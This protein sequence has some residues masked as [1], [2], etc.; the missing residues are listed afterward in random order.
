MQN[1]FRDAVR[2]AARHLKF[3]SDVGDLEVAWESHGGLLLCRSREKIWSFEIGCHHRRLRPQGRRC[4]LYTVKS[5]RSQTVRSRYLRKAALHELQRLLHSRGP[6]SEEEYAPINSPKPRATLRRRKLERL[7]SNTAPV[8]PAQLISGRVKV[9]WDWKA[10]SRCAERWTFS[11]P[12][13]DIEVLEEMD[14][15][16]LEVQHFV[17][18]NWT[19]GDVECPAAKC[20]ESSCPGGTE[21]V[22]SSWKLAPIIVAHTRIA[23]SSLDEDTTQDRQNDLWTQAMLICQLLDPEVL[24]ASFE[25]S[26]PI[27]KSIS[28]VSDKS[29]LE[30]E[31][32]LQDCFVALVQ[33]LPSILMSR[34]Y[35]QYPHRNELVAYLLK[36]TETLARA[37]SQAS[38]PIRPHSEEVPNELQT[39]W[40]TVERAAFHNPTI[41]AATHRSMK[42]R[43]Q[44]D[45]S[46]T[47]AQ[48]A[49]IIR[50]NLLRRQH[51]DPN[52]P[53][54]SVSWFC[55]KH[56]VHRTQVD[57]AMSRMRKDGYEFGR[58]EGMKTYKLSTTDE[59]ELL[60]RLGLTPTRAVVRRRKPSF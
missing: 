42:H 19:E 59:S 48:L 16:L 44:I 38:T 49:E 37:S 18:K 39:P 52:G 7:I 32:L 40:E 20:I 4:K 45:G 58:V 28:R 31:E 1:L 11:P 43:K 9:W 30:L 5:S 34:H 22:Q 8:Y 15:F 26:G 51:R 17:I 3:S 54:R 57:R 56:N 24:G 13:E 33:R 2:L 23:N 53:D 60:R 36:T 10:P 29:S 35:S 41:C 50:L 46:E 47:S 25:T 6:V 21:I 14:R 12:I 55:T 27:A